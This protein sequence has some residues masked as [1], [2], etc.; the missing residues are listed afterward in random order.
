MVLNQFRLISGLLSQM[1]KEHNHKIL[2][3]EGTLEII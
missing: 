3:L 1:L 2:E